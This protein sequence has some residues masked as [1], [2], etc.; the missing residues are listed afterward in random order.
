MHF[1]IEKN[2]KSIFSQWNIEKGRSIQRWS[3]SLPLSLSDRCVQNKYLS[4][5][6]SNV[7][8]HRRAHWYKSHGNLK[9]YPK[10]GYVFTV[11]DLFVYKQQMILKIK[12]SKLNK[13][14]C[15]RHIQHPYKT[16]KSQIVSSTHIATE[17]EQGKNSIKFIN[18]CVQ[19]NDSP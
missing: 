7:N 17:R 16:D 4:P 1:V 9:I 19:K 6:H 10:T 2:Y 13:D 14:A 12:R 3:A 15:Q 11:L 18:I 8:F 5:H